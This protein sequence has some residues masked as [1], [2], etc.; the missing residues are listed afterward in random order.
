[1]WLASRKA[2][3]VQRLALLVDRV[4]CVYPGS[5]V[6]A[7]LECLYKT[8]LPSEFFL[9]GYVGKEAGGKVEVEKGGRGDGDGTRVPSLVMIFLNSHPFVPFSLAVAQ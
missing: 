9:E 8:S 5:V 2:E 3:E 6:V 7:L 4:R 1:M